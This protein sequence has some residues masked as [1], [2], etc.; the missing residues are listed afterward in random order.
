MLESI[1]LRNSYENS[2]D[3]NVYIITKYLQ[4][5]ISLSKYLENTKKNIIANIDLLKPILLN[6]KNFFILMNEVGI[7]HNDLDQHLNNI[8]I[9]PEIFDMKI[10]DYG[11]CLLKSN[12]N[13]KFD[14][15]LL[16]QKN[17]VLLLILNKLFTFSRNRR[18][19]IFSIT[20]IKN[21]LERYFSPELS[22]ELYNLYYS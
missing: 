7:L 22:E 9:N 20:N 8:M 16:Y 4:N 14:E 2:D 15:K 5:Y 6:L 12:S 11:L 18:N 1:I 10:I 13:S 17:M 3:N 21:I 19:L